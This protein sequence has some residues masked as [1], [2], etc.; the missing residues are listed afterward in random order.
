M[1]TSACFYNSL[2][3]ILS[4]GCLVQ[5]LV[6]HNLDYLL[7]ISPM[8]FT[9]VS[10]T[11]LAD[12]EKA[13]DA[14]SSQSWSHRLLPTPTALFPAVVESEEDDTDSEIISRRRS[15]SFFEPV[16]KGS[17]GIFHQESELD[18]A[19]AKQV[20]ALKKKL[21]QIEALELKQFRG[22][23]LDHQQE[24]K[25]LTKQT[26]IDAI[27][28]IESGDATASIDDNIEGSGVQDFHAKMVVS[29][30]QQSA[31]KK[32]NKSSIEHPAS[33]AYLKEKIAQASKLSDG[34]SFTAAEDPK[35]NADGKFFQTFGNKV[36]L[37]FALRR[38]W[39]NYILHP[40][41]A[42]YIFWNILFVI[43]AIFLRQLYCFSALAFQ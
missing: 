32:K 29:R 16:K 39:F 11:L 1:Q 34:K 18:Q 36:S 3:F 31:R 25:L 10:P 17:E 40:L 30:K 42:F 4:V 14:T 41:L 7:A 2:K 9:H 19:K 12:V 13:L 37:L 21:Q 5:E 24:A 8:T 28:A 27:L 6:L 15:L 23:K 33:E 35:V 20:R 22:H 26:L 38:I 43:F